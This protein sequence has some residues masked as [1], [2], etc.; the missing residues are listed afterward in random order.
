ML[1]TVYKIILFYEYIIYCN[2]K[3][4][5]ANKFGGGGGGGQTLF[6][7]TAEK[8]PNIKLNAPNI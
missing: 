2:C 3:V 6:F 5:R 1:N 8:L 4:Y 7:P